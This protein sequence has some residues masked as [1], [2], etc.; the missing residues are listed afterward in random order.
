[1]YRSEVRPHLC[2]VWYAGTTVKLPWQL[3]Q[4]QLMSYRERD[5]HRFPRNTL[6]LT[7]IHYKSEDFLHVCTFSGLMFRDST[8]EHFSHWHNI[9][10]LLLLTIWLVD[11]LKSTYYAKS[12]F[13]W[14]LDINVCWQWVNTTTL[15]WCCVRRFVKVHSEHYWSIHVYVCCSSVIANGLWK[16]YKYINVSNKH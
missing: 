3:Q 6:T 16:L 14:C 1:M 8:R 4:T 9:I 7:W 12:T 13:T 11:N 15:Q 10:G 2:P 5:A